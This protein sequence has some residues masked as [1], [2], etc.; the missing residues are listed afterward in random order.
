MSYCSDDALWT[1]KRYDNMNKNTT[2]ENVASNNRNLLE[3]LRNVQYK[4]LQ[5]ATL[6]SIT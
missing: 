2:S 3:L 1:D 5:N 4:I 6:C